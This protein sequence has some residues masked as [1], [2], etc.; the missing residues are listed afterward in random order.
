ME[1]KKDAWTLLIIVKISFFLQ[2]LTSHFRKNSKSRHFKIARVFKT[3]I[4]A[5]VGGM[6]GFVAWD[7]FD[8]E[9]YLIRGSNPNPVSVSMKKIDKLD[10]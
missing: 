10:S 2:Y 9:P 7:H 5:E 1:H 4:G 6:D 3:E 8:P